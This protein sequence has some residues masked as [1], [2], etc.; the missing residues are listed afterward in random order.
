MCVCFH[1]SYFSVAGRDFRALCDSPDDGS[2][3]CVVIDGVLDCCSV[4][5]YRVVVGNC[6]F[7]FNLDFC[8]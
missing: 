6:G 7:F 4:E 2:C 5:Y 8:S 3:R 1:F